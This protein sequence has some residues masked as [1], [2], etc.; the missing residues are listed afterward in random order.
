MASVTHIELRAVAEEIDDQPHRCE[1]EMGVVDFP[2]VEFVSPTA[3]GSEW[4][5][6][7]TV[8]LLIDFFRCHPRTAGGAKGGS[9]LPHVACLNITASL[10]NLVETQGTKKNTP[11]T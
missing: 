3:R 10:L 7:T 11:I 9:Q 5:K 1:N 2:V 4:V 6:H 8:A